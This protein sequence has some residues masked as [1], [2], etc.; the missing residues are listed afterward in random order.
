SG[1][2]FTGAPV[3]IKPD[4]RPHVV[5]F[6]AHWCPHCN[7]ELPALVDELRAH[8]LPAAVEMT[9]VSTAV[10]PPATNYPPQ[11]WLEQ[12]IKWPTPV[13][14]DDGRNTAATAFGLGSYPYFV[15]VDA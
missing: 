11:E 14:A 8:P 12:T 6:A 4:G 7:R 1:Q 2:S 10:M 3:E 15:F 9:V 13:M 5:L